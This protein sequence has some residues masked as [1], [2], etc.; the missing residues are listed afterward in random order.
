[1]AQRFF[2]VALLATL[3]LSSCASSA[4]PD[5]TGHRQPSILQGNLTVA[6]QAVLSQIAR[7][8][9]GFFDADIDSTTHLP[10]D[11]FGLDG[12]SSKRGTYTSPTN[13]GVYFWS[14]V[15]AQDLSIISRAAAL[16]RAMAT[17]T[18]VE[19]LSKWN[20]FLFSWYDTTDGHRIS[21]PGGT[22]QEGQPAGGAFISTVDNA[23]YATGLILLRQVYPELAS[24]ATMLLNAMDFSIFYDHG[25]QSASETAGQMYGGYLAN[26][27]PATFHY[28]L[29]NT[30]TR[31]GAYIGI[32]THRMPGDVWWR[33]WRTMPV[34]YTWQG[35]TPQGPLVTMTDPQS[36]KQFSV[37][38]GHYRY[39]DFH[40]IPSWG[41][42]MFEGLMTN[43]VIPETSWGPNSFGR[44]DQ[45]YAQAQITY[46]QQRLHFPVWGLS[47]SSTPDDT[48][49]YDA[50]GAHALATNA[51]TS[52]YEETAV[53]PYAS[54][55]ALTV[56]PQEAFTNIQKLRSL[57]G[58]YGPY[59]FFDAVNPV[60]GR[61]S[62]RY[63]VLDQSM[64][65]AALDDTL[66]GQAMQQHFAHDPVIAAD[67][68]YLTLET[69][70]I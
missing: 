20:G 22:D 49:H 8:T 1:M 10:M 52:P 28:S 4:T 36:G 34:N 44:N 56:A 61:V 47:P 70:S 29:L 13:I 15:A 38:E 51:N 25:N 45:L 33:T 63:F 27:G 7:Q 32:G 68:A 6:Q 11:N 21:G 5:A 37:F 48:G 64:I 17:L 50:Y 60:T 42:S 12:A 57:D 67:H 9:W 19:H 41:G 66:H 58:L 40:F 55:L 35:Q 31:I 16:Q 26:E 54:F 14:V 23:W 30:E 18:A 69:F 24:H 62:H 43:L 39:G 3:S 59:G 53:T 65:M 46:A 2:L